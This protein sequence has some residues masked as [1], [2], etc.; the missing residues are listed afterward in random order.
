MLWLLGFLGLRMIR[1]AAGCDPETPRSALAGWALAGAAVA[2][3][4]V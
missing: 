1:E 3:S 2:T 4:I